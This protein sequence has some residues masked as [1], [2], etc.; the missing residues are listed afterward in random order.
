MTRDPIYKEL[1]KTM[2]PPTDQSE[3]MLEILAISMTPDEVEMVMAL[4][5]SNIDLAAKFNLDEKAVEKKIHQFM[6][7]GL[8]HPSPEGPV[9]YKEVGLLQ[10]EMLSSDPAIVSIKLVRL[11]DEYYRTEMIKDLE[12]WFVNTKPP[13]LRIVPQRKA[14]PEGVDLMPCEDLN[15]IIKAAKSATVRDCP[16]RVARGDC[17]LPIHTCVQ[18]NERADYAVMRG[19]AKDITREEVFELEAKAE[20]AGMVPMV[21]NVTSMAAQN[22]ICMCCSCCCV[23]IDPLKK[24]NRLRKEEGLA[25]SR[26]QAEVN[27]E[28]CISCG[29]CVKRCQFGAIKMGKVEGEKKRKATIDAEL[30]YG[31][32]ACVLTCEPEALGLKLVRPPEHIPTEHPLLI[33]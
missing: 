27:I 13:M 26:F 21:A 14:V 28:E 19:A 7:K 17:N 16:C 4:P 15:E 25:K 2:L 6:R 30:C 32:G 24:G 12:E 33:S 10:D 22:Y 20:E 23:V 8:V 18:F 5:A 1:A 3:L 31:C 9:F 11:W 29:K